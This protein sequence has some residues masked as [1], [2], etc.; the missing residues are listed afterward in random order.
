[1]I[2]LFLYLILTGYSTTEKVE[3]QKDKETAIEL[4]LSRRRWELFDTMEFRNAN[5]KQVRFLL[6]EIIKEIKLLKKQD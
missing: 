3:I 5:D 2:Y 4:E 1:M 6:G